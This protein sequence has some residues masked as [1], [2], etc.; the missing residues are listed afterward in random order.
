MSSSDG[1]Q[2]AASRTGDTSTRHC[3]VVR[4]PWQP[5]LSDPLD[6]PSGAIQ[7]LVW[8]FTAFYRDEWGN[9]ANEMLEA[10]NGQLQRVRQKHLQRGSLAYDRP[11]E[12]FAVRRACRSAA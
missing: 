5:L 11:P 8:F 3:K 9:V 10:V 12:P 7:G 1:T 6:P 2:P 4:V